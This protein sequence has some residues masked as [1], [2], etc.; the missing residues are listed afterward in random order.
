MKT[1][2]AID[3]AI[4]RALHDKRVVGTVV[5]VAQ[6]GKVVF[7]R[8]AGYANREAKVPMAEDALFRLASLSKPL[9]SAAAMAL[10]E[11]RKLGLDDTLERWLHPSGI[12]HRRDWGSITVRQLLTHTSGLGYR[13][14][15]PPDSPYEAAAISD[16]LD[17][18]PITLDE[19]VR[20]LASVPLLFP[21]G[22]SWNYSLSIDVLGAVLERAA[23]SGLAEVFE[24]E[25][26]RPLGMTETAFHCR[27][28]QR[29]TAQ[30]VDG[31]PEPVP[32]RDPDDVF[33]LGS[34]VRFSPSRA[35]N[36]AA[37]PSGGGGMV[38]SSDDFMRFL[39]ALLDGGRP[40]LKPDTVRA[41]MSN[42]IGTLQTLRGPGFGFGF[43]GAVVTDPAAAQTP[44]SVGTLGW[45]GV[46]GH[47][48]FVDPQK[49]IAV[50]C[51]TNTA[52]EGMNGLFT[53]ELRDAVYGVTA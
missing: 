9:V 47:S 11:Q 34:T 10:V 35:L 24:R 2:K 4:D 13:M 31:K 28:P 1:S 46:Y 30:Y 42:H 27:H 23:G 33:F 38:G 18:S 50:L 48:W 45:G 3:A 29:L 8:A 36:P 16:G 7:R 25:I 20:R 53:V 26:G 37:Y 12:A 52:F 32:M 17:E 15:M 49:E 22:T 5:Q 43:G 14:A 21:P 41:M 44:Q 19:N 6:G 51:M 40:I 39:L